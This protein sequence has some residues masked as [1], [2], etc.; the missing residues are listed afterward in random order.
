MQMSS[1]P[2]GATDWSKVESTEHKGER[3]LDTSM[4]VIEDLPVPRTR[5]GLR[6]EVFARY[7]RRQV[8]R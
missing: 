2:F 1:I 3:G 8:R 6:T 7:H 5:G 4:G